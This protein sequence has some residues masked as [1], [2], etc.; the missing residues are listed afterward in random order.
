MCVIEKYLNR[1][2]SLSRNG[3]IPLKINYNILHRI[4]KYL[5]KNYYMLKM[6]KKKCFFFNMNIN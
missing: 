5:K 4:Y 2:N 3:F 1:N 6:K